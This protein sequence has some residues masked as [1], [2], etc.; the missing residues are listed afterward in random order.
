M[1]KRRNID[2]PV[3]KQ[4]QWVDITTYGDLP[5]RRFVCANCGETRTEA[6]PECP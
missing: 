4:H 3:A 2:H 6:P 1:R 5:N